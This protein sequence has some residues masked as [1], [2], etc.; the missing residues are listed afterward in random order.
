M[1]PALLGIL[2]SILDKIFPDKT[3]AERAKARLIELQV[4]GELEALK[5]QLEINKAEA[6][7]GSAYAAGWRPTVGYICAAGLAYNFLFYPMAVWY[8]AK[9]APGFVPP[10]LVSD[11][12]MELVFGMLGLGGLR[13]FEKVKGVA[14]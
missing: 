6:A 11:N 2:P 7:S 14:K 8:A 3:E 13:T 4:T 5:G 10:P 12:L 9:Y 1:W